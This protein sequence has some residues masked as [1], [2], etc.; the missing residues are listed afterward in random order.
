ML[1]NLC[2]FATDYGALVRELTDPLKLR[3]S[4]RIVQ[5]PFT[6]P[7]ENEKTE[8]ELVKIAERR[9]EQG[10]K[11]QEMAANKRVEKVL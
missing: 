8:E 1:H 2:E 5:F 10:K 4:E 9:K 7:V 3:A 11:L 6:A